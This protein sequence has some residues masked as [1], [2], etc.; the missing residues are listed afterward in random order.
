MRKVKKS[1]QTA[2]EN[3]TADLG[4]LIHTESR[5]IVSIHI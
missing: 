2:T 1:P 5:L 4:N 3:I